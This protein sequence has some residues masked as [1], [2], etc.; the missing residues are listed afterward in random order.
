MEIRIGAELRAADDDR[1]LVGH[2]AV[3][4]SRSVDL[5]GFVEVI[6]PGAFATSLK[7]DDIRALID[8]QG[9]AIARTGNGT[10][11]LSEDKT[12]LLA[13]I[14]LPDT[15]AGRDIHASVK[16]G[17]VDGMS[18]GFSVR[19]GGQMF[20][21]DESGMT[22]RTLTDIRLFEVSVV[23]FP[24]YPDTAVAAR[25][26]RDWRGTRNAH[27]LARSRMNTGLGLRVRRL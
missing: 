13:E 12:G 10:L 9:I 21:E 6:Q 24:A 4:N 14:D 20:T 19:D 5:G 2:A 8:H 11:K 7:S 26:V 17:D 18:F 22:I 3:F 15:T 27:L 16:R 25:S 1:R 23:T